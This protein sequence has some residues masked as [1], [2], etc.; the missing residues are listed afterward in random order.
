MAIDHTILL[1]TSY[2]PPIEYFVRI[3]GAQKVRID[4]H[5]TY[6]RQTWRNRCNILT[7]NG[8]LSLSIPVEKPLGNHTSTAQVRISDHSSWQKNHWRSIE[9]AYRNAPYFLFYRQLAEEFVMSTQYN[10]LVDLNHAIL[11]AFCEELDV[12]ADIDFTSGF[13]QNC[14][15][16]LDLRF[17][18]SP[19]NRDR[20]QY[21]VPTLAPYYQTF[22][23]KWGFQPNLSILDLLFNLGPDTA[24]YLR[25]AV[26][27]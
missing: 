20:Q 25:K 6:A 10:L 3:M 7:A 9:A 21:P 1:A 27:A 14:A 12:S 8:V 18:I 4:I 22:G 5:E 11:N 15:A 26:H 23:D 16:A 19:K 17:C 2:F 24:E 13:V